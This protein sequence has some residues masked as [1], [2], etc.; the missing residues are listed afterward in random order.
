[1]S[2]PSSFKRPAATAF[3]IQNQGNSGQTIIPA[4]YLKVTV[5][6]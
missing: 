2:Q 3:E 1:M 6:V 5:E 4:K